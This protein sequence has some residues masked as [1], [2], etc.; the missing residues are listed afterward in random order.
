M[1]TGS[2]T[3]ANPQKT[4]FYE[5]RCT[6]Q[7]DRWRGMR[8]IG[9]GLLL[10]LLVSLAPFVGFYAHNLS[11]GI[12]PGDLWV[13]SALTFALA[14]GSYLALYAAFKPSDHRISSLIAVFVVALFNFEATS[15]LMATHGIGTAGQ[16]LGWIVFLVGA[17]TVTAWFGGR[18][19]FH[20]VLLLFAALNLAA[21]L[22]LFVGYDSSAKGAPSA[23]ET[24]RLEGN[25]IWSGEPVRKPNIYWLVVDSYP[26][27][28]QLREV[29]GFDNSDFVTFLRA[30][31]FYVADESYSNYA[32]TVLS[33]PSTL[34]M[35]VVFP[36]EG[37]IREVRGGTQ[38]LLPGRTTRG[39]LDA[40]GGD[41]RTVAYLKQLG[42]R[43]VHFAD[44]WSTKVRCRGYEDVCIRG[45]LTS[46]TEL[47]SSL[48]KLVPW[49]L[50]QSAMLRMPML[51]LA[52]PVGSGTLVPEFTEELAR[53][54]ED[55]GPYFVYAHFISPH[56][57]FTNDAECDVFPRGRT[58][59][60]ADGL[61]AFLEQILCL[62]RHLG[63]LLDDLLARD[64]EAIVILSA[65]HGARFSPAP[66]TRLADLTQT[67]ILEMLGILN[68]IRV[69]ETCRSHLH[70]RIAPV[71]VMRLV[72]ACLGGH[73]PR[74]I[75]PRF[76]VGRPRA[77]PEH[78]SVR[79][80]E[81][82]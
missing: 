21:S 43:Y 31:G 66:E 74:F 8:M 13:F 78:G 47:Q 4:G 33:V 56:E 50:V 68:A 38:F 10:L 36:A 59:S 15:S 73:E 37:A 75:E 39:L 41:N 9:Q 2:R 22:S 40:I 19:G 61:G 23:L 77:N 57:P 52:Q 48:L 14:A 11:Q 69:P 79:R 44:P 45:K 20:K 60:R 26:S 30:R 6:T 46:F 12:K 72:F 42:Y 64:P 35:E 16:K 62:N 3:L 76:F 58:L 71:N 67:E 28:L 81:V 5:I 54:P 27:E 29:F 82:F 24:Y 17:L 49:D 51:S 55:E 34:Q 18:K 32:A 7:V 25:P 1:A 65:D 63:A 70:P 80:V 53:L